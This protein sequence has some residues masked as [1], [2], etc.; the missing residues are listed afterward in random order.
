MCLQTEWHLRQAL[1]GSVIQGMSKV[2]WDFLLPVVLWTVETTAA[3]LP[4]A[5]PGLQ[6]GAGHLF[7]NL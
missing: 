2:G 5:W 1:N 4:V 6:K 7:C 3:A